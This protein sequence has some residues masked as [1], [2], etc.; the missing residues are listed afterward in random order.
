MLDIQK[1]INSA[2]DFLKEKFSYKNK[3]QS[4]KLT[5]IV[6]SVGV[7]RDKED[8]RK[9]GV[10]LDRLTKITGQ[11]PSE[12]PAKKSIAAFKLREGQIVGYKVTM[13]GDKM[14]R[15]FDKFVGIVMPRMKDFRGISLQSVDE[16]GNLTM[17]IKEHIVFPETGDEEIKDIF[18]LAVTIVSSASSKDEALEFFKHIGIPFKK[19]KENK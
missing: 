5:K 18:S 2:F 7:G 16:Q 15:F 14:H 4:P 17:G 11:K 19:E 1:K 6:V 13:R 8:K 12:S 9:L 3:F 10:I